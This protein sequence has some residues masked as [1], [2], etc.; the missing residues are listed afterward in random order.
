MSKA[1]LI[2]LCLGLA[3]CGQQFGYF[4]GQPVTRISVDGS[5]FDVRVHDRLAEA[6]RRNPEYAPR[7]GPLLRKAEIAMTAVSGCPV[8][9]IGGDQAV[10]T[11]ILECEAK[12]QLIV[13]PLGP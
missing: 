13:L 8:A 6:V 5:V 1:G 2:V 9:M 4:A 7:M 11:G 10:F 3:A 12:A